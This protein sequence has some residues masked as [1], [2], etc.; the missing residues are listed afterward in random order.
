MIMSCDALF[1]VRFCNDYV[2]LQDVPLH[3]QAVFVECDGLFGRCQS[4]TVC[5]A[6]FSMNHMSHEDD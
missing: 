1:T 3:A 6:L 5:L 4:D 2:L